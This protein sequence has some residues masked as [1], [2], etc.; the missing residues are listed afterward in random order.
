MVVRAG[1]PVCKWPGNKDPV[2]KPYS[3]EKE[4]NEKDEGKGGEGKVN[5]HGI[6]VLH[7]EEY[8]HKYETEKDKG[9]LCRKRMEIG[10]SSAN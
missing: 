9:E 7:E 4:R 5:K 8:T 2:S 6:G 10:G 3:C 1:I